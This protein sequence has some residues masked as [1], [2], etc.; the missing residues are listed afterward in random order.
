MILRVMWKA[1][2]VY[3]VAI[4]A[5]SLLAALAAGPASAYIRQARVA[6]ARRALAQMRKKFGEHVESVVR[7]TLH[8]ARMLASA[9]LPLYAAPVLQSALGI[10]RGGAGLMRSDEEA[11]RRTEEVLRETPAGREA[12]A[13]TEEHGITVVYKPGGLDGALGSYQDKLNL[14]LIGVSGQTPEELAETFVHEV[15]HARNEGEPNPLGMGR[16]EYI[17]AAIEEEVD[18]QVKAY[19]MR[20]QLA[21]ARG[22]QLVHEGEYGWAYHDAVSVENTERERRGQPSLSADEA[23]RVG[24][25]A[26]REALR[27]WARSAGYEEQFGQEWSLRFLRPVADILVPEW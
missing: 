2:V 5:V 1:Y 19:E 7:D 12:L 25:E 8:R 13:W 9:L 20:R 27:A 3:A 11:Q 6:G 24:D 15:N 26:G 21:A 23:Q 17:R 10:Y 16:E 18:G 14:L 4:L 22:E